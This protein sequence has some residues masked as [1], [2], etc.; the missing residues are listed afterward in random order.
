MISRDSK[1][2]IEEAPSAAHGADLEM[3]RESDGSYDTRPEEER[4]RPRMYLLRNPSRDNLLV[5]KCRSARQLSNWAFQNNAK[6]VKQDF[7]LRGV[8]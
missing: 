4:D 8:E 6:S 7:D 5:A 1:D 2:V 3:H